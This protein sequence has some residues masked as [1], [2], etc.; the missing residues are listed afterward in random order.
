MLTL[1]HIA[2]EIAVGHKLAK[3][4][5][6]ELI[7]QI[8]E[9]ITKRLKKGDKIRLTGLGHPSGEEGSCSHEP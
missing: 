5:A 3:R 2:K 7:T 6:N 4:Q 9:I 8:V 1:R